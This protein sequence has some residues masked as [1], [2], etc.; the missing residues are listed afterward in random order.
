MQNLNIYLEK[1]IG[2]QITEKSLDEALDLLQ[3]VPEIQKQLDDPTA[4][5]ENR[6]KLMIANSAFLIAGGANMGTVSEGAL[7]IS[8]MV[9][10]QTTVYEIEEFIH[11]PDLQL[12]PESTLFFTC[13]EDETKERVLQ[14]CEAS[15]LITENTFLVR[16]K[17]LHMDQIY[18]PLY[19]TAFSIRFNMIS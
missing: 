8:E 16:F 18:A 9:H 10:I 17:D 1:M 15:G 11:G 6:E 4:S 3:M 7:K 12:T 5:Q 2:E 14:V 19:F 13:V